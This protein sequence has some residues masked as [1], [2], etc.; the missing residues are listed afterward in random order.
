M[1]EGETDPKPA[2]AFWAGLSAALRSVFAVVMA[3]TY[4]GMG[5]LA[6]QYGL[7]AWWLTL[8]TVLIWAGP[9][10][11]ILIAIIG[12]GGS[13]WAAALAVWFA[14]VRFFPMV[15][16][17]LPLLRARDGSLRKL[18]LPVHLTTQSMWVESLRLLPGLPAKRRIPFCNGLAAG[19][20]GIAVLFGL[21]GYFLAVELP[22]LL[23]AGL[24]FLTPCR[25]CCRSR[26]TRAPRSTAWRSVSASGCPRC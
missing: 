16:T 7:S 14:G 12:G 19:Y 1:P 11:L 10:Q 4:I 24:I 23:S 2:Q 6:H 3:G 9:A 21:V 13:L 8:S 18:L 22:P 20:I 5:A 26:A 15:V 17:L 25:S